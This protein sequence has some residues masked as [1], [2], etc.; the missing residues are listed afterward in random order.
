MHDFVLRLFSRL[1]SDVANFYVRCAMILNGVGVSGLFLLAWRLG[2][3]GITGML[4]GLN[5]LVM[6]GSHWFNG[7]LYANRLTGMPAL[8]ENWALPFLFFQIAAL[9]SHLRRSGHP[10]HV[11]RAR[12]SVCVWTVLAVLAWQFTQFLLWL[13]LLALL[14][15]HVTG[16]GGGLSRIRDTTR[17]ILLGI[18]IA[19]VVRAEE[20]T[21]KHV[22]QLC[23]Y[24]RDW[25]NKGHSHWHSLT[26][27]MA[28][29]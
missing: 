20:V 11:L 15:V 8:R 21:R 29:N 1:I 6:W 7:Y 14:C 12:T 16:W 26:H 18:A 27:S 4:C 22:N 5:A 23:I 25:P 10:R 28:C 13:E 17:C 9:C 3:R 19:T 2:D 24:G